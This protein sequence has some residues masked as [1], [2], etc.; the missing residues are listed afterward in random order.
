MRKCKCKLKYGD[1][2][3]IS[4]V[5]WGWVYFRDYILDLDMVGVFFKVI[6]VKEGLVGSGDFKFFRI[7]FFCFVVLL[8]LYFRSRFLKI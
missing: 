6:D 4:R 2:Y 7:F 1:Y 3:R 8:I 5:C